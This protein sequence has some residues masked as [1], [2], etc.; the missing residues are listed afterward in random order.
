MELE[1]KIEHVRKQLCTQEEFSIRDFFLILDSNRNGLVSFKNFCR[2]LNILGFEVTN[3]LELR[4]LFDTID[5]SSDSYIS[6]ED[7]CGQLLPIDRELSAQI[8]KKRGR[9]IAKKNR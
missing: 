8:M 4:L 7:L 3:P 9:F 5:S 6:F 2:F 1:M